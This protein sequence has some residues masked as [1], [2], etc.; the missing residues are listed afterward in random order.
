MT[1]SLRKLTTAM[2]TR[3]GFRVIEGRDAAEARKRGCHRPRAQRLSHAANER[4]AVGSGNSAVVSERN[5]A[6]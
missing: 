4:P 6:N 3:H 2:L 5:S 1:D